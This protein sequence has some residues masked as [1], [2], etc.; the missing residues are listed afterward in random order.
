MALEREDRDAIVEAIREGFKSA[1]SPTPAPGNNNNSP[2]VSGKLYKSTE[3]FGRI[4][5]EGGG[6]IRNFT[7]DFNKALPEV[8][9]GFG[10]AIGN[11]AGYIEDTQGVFQSLQKSGLGLGGNLGDLR[12]QAARTRMPLDQFANMVSKN[13]QQLVGLAGNASDGA[14]RFADLSNA[15]F[16]GDPSPIEGFMNLGYSIEEANEF[17]IKNTELNR[18]QAMLQGMTD[19]EQVK[20]AQELAKNMSI[21]AKLTGKDAQQMQ[22]EL[23]ARQRNGATQA[24]L[25]LLEMDGVTGA[26]EA[27]NRAQTALDAAPDVVGNLFDDLMQTGAPM[28]EATKNFAATNQEAYAL[29]Q[30]AAEANKRGDIEEA[31]RLAQEAAAATAEFAQSRQGLTLATLAQVSDIAQGQANVLEE[32]GPVIDGINANV[33][34]IK[35]A[36]GQ[37]LTFRQAFNANLA[38]ISANMETQVA[39]QNA[40]QE[41]LTAANTAQIGLANT[42]SAANTMLGE[43]IETNSL[44]LSAY[45]TL[46]ENI[47][48][49][50]SSSTMTFLEAINALIPGTTIA[51]NIPKIE[52][53]ATQ[54][55]EAGHISE[56]TIANLKTLADST[57]S[58]VEKNSARDALVTEGVL[59]AAGNISAELANALLGMRREN[60]ESS[61]TSEGSSGNW[62][63]RLWDA[64]TGST[65]QRNQGSL[66]SGSLF[67]NFGDGTLLTAHDL[68]SIQT[69]SQMAEV[70]NSALSG[71]MSAMQNQ[72]GGGQFDPNQL[73]QATQEAMAS[74]PANVSRSGESTE[75]GL[76]SL[77]QTMLQLV[78][79]NSKVLETANKQLRA[80]KGLDG[81]MMT[82]V[83]I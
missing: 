12:V 3:G 37:E 17:V 71:A 32:M 79:I 83:G 39:G 59:D 6:S 10:G 33:A 1:P 36:T 52:M 51:E 9:Q 16:K 54:L 57:A 80:T 78:Q 82:S 18:R 14:K 61:D 27:Y 67:E 44:L 8:L 22:D 28:T 43:Q 50:L 11:V 76:D 38:T 23:I 70:V 21:V 74:M 48:S 45:Q 68:E 34:A 13:S 2:D 46:N 64:I 41:A 56:S 66:G 81:N 49:E 15:M 53:F 58:Q 20:Q 42:A 29:L 4:L 65:P 75:N 55:Q 31:E 60:M 26:Q 77:N 35:D 24:R 73:A 7:R 69:P 5:D 62:F 63:T 30:Q 47:H 72:L 25:R 19:A 40:G